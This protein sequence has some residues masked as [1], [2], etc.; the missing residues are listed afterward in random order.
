MG[1]SEKK[2]VEPNEKEDNI[3][4]S[5]AMI[6]YS[7]DI[8]NYSDAVSFLQ[9][10][11]LDKDNITRILC[12]LIVLKI[13]P[14]SQLQSAIGV[15]KLVTKYQKESKNNLKDF[16]DDPLSAIPKNESRVIVAD[17]NRSIFWFETMAKQ[18]KLDEYYFKSVRERVYRIFSLISLRKESY[19]QGFDRYVLISYL[20]GLIFISKSG[21][22]PDVAEALSFFI[23][24]SLISIARPGDLLADNSVTEEHFSKL[25]KKINESAPEVGQIMESLGISSILFALR[26]QLL[27]FA[28]EH[29]LKG[30]LFIWD[31]VIVH[32][33]NYPQ[34]I[35]NLSVAHIC[36]IPK[37]ST[38]NIIETIQ[39]FRQWD[40]LEIVRKA[41]FLCEKKNG[42]E[43]RVGLFSYLLFII[44]LVIIVWYIYDALKIE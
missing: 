6:R 11:D 20:L 15:S 41:D 29:D 27:I 42:K 40:N 3:S 33:L 19:I 38:G 10:P 43:R 22:S 21:L 9:K 13:I 32:S 37:D 18:V 2:K 7:N 4:I 35:E 25:D 24:R 34:Y 16:Y 31:N 39:R 23:S 36:Q 5:N 12:W 28:D 14:D 26:W 1:K 17:I 44:L 8:L 30:T